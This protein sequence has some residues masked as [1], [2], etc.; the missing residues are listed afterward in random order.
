MPWSTK[1]IKYRR[2]VNIIIIAALFAVLK[3]Y[4][5]IALRG[6][7]NRI[8]DITCYNFWIITLCHEQAYH[9]VV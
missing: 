6:I 7:T 8:F 5:Y 1:L 4:V 2:K 9:Y 3:H